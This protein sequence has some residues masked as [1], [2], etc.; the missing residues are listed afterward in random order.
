MGVIE[1]YGVAAL[2][3]LIIVTVLWLISVPIKDAS[4][5]DMFWGPLF[6]AIAWVL[7]P[8]HGAGL[9]SRSY[10]LVLL[11]TLWGLRLAF[12]LANRNL[13]G[14]EDRRYA[15]WREHG[16]PHWWLTTYYRIFLFQGV[17]ALAVATPLIAGFYRPHGLS[18]VNA[19]GV[20]VWA[21]GFVYELVADVQLTRYLAR[22]PAA[23]QTAATGHPA[24]LNSGLWRYSRHPNYFGDALQWWG[25]GIVAFS[26]ETWWSL[27][28]PLVM[29]LIFLV[30][31]ANILERGMAK[32]HPDYEEYVTQTPKFFPRLVRDP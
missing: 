1:L 31:T 13:G 14:G 18:L 8:V 22:A 19:A 15:R 4:I 25:L 32:R 2:V 10:L 30:L 11:V 21:A 20:L 29:T 27:L 26:A 17:L 9:Q 23:S 7:L 28:G 5:I 12:H 16:G 3:V 24:L 6:V